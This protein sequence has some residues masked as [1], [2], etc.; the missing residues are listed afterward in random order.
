[1]DDHGAPGPGP[2]GRVVLVLLWAVLAVVPIATGLPDLRLAAG[3]T[4][5]P[6]TL[7]VDQCTELGRGRYDC[8]GSFSPDGGGPAVA[9]AAPPDSAAGETWPARLGPAGDRAVRADVAGLW[10][11]SAV[12][13][14]GVAALA[15]LPLL[16]LHLAGVARG[17]RV[18]LL[19]GAPVAV[20]ALTGAVGGVIAAS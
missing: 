10:V 7:T 13:L 20:V 11:A 3:A 15:L 14:L 16:G 9:V 18:A 12:P 8:R 5:T 17:R 6:G 19:L 1:M 4:G 2:V